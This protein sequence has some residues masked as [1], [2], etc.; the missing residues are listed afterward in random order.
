[1]QMYTV[2]VVS[3]LIVSI[4]EKLSN[5]FSLLQFCFTCFIQ[6]VNLSDPSTTFSLL[7]DYSDAEREHD[8]SRLFFGRVVCFYRLKL[9]FQ[10]LWHCLMTSYCK[11]TLKKLDLIYWDGIF[12]ISAGHIS[13]V[14]NK[15][16]LNNLIWLIEYTSHVFILSLKRLQK[17]NG[18]C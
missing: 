10:K 18:T 12:C 9:K 3:Y 17:A 16:T 13:C 4:V 2:H 15:P 14:K 5:I 6:N 8:P 1:M 11:K 7:L